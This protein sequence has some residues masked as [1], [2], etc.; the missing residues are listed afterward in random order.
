MIEVLIVYL[1]AKEKNKE[2][3]SI[4]HG[5]RNEMTMISKRDSD[6]TETSQCYC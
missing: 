2:T 4:Q 3:E 6:K 5:D 1:A